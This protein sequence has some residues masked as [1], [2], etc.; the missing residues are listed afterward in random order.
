[1][2]DFKN[3]EH[4]L[5]DLPFKL[6]WSIAGS[7][8]ALLLIG[9]L[10]L[11][12]PEWT[13]NTVDFLDWNCLKN[14][15]L[16]VEAAKRKGEKDKLRKEK[17][18]VVRR[19]TGDS[20]LTGTSQTIKGQISKRKSTIRIMRPEEQSALPPIGHRKWMLSPFGRRSKLTSKGQGEV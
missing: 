19:G 14:S 18:S 8:T 5:V 10:F 15:R 17:N 1:M 2:F 4:V 11:T 7:V 13:T 6:Y 16:Y 12:F 20:E 3:T 9:Q